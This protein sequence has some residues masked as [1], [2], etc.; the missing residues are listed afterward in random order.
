MSSISLCRKRDSYSLKQKL[1]IVF[2]ATQIGRNKAAQQH[3]LDA[4]MVGRWM[5][6]YGN[7]DFDLLAL[8]NKN[9]KRI[10]F[11]QRELFVEEEN[12]LYQ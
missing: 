3:N 12:S 4:T 6:K 7:F 8:D 5:K 11:G 2:L 9:S 10:R 1:D